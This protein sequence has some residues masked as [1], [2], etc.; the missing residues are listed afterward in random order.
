MTNLHDEIDG[1]LDACQAEQ[2]MR[3]G[4]GHELA[5]GI[6]HGPLWLAHDAAVAEVARLCRLVAAKADQ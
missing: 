3:A 5:R 1:L 6:D 2:S 4:V